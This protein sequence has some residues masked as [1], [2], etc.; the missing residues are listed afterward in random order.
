MH[1]GPVQRESGPILDKGILD[2]V[3]GTP[4]ECG[5][6]SPEYPIGIA[7]AHPCGF[8]VW[9]VSLTREGLVLGLRALRGR[10]NK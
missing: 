3:V 10:E 6:W 8:S 4:E 1:K 9:W 5:A 7:S 2:A